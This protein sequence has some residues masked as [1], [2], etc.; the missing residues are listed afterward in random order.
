MNKNILL[1]MVTFLLLILLITPVSAAQDLYKI[2]VL[3]FDDGSIDEVWWGDYNVGSGVSDELVTALLNLT[4]QK[5]RVM[6]REQIQRVLEEQEFGASG[7]V[8]ASS[9]AKIGK[10]LGVQFLL[11]GKVTEFTN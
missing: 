6:E 7:L 9:A 3:P 5:F 8:D 11:I 4:P 1:T 10:I 2:A